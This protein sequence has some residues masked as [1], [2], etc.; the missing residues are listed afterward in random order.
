VAACFLWFRYRGW[1]GNRDMD[2]PEDVD[3]EEGGD[4]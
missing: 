2:V 3:K 1:I 4:E